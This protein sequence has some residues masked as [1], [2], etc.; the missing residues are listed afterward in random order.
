MA[1][2]GVS[3]TMN[4]RLSLEERLRAVVIGVPAYIRRRRLIED[5]IAAAVRDVRAFRDAGADA[6]AMRA[7]LAELDL[8]RINDL[9]DRH[10]RYYPVEANLPI[11]PVTGGLIDRVTR[12]P[13]QPME[14]VTAATILAQ[15]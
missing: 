12:A 2:G 14:P 8:A 4:F 1:D 3:L 15:L 5:L 7:K 9:I 6:A 10:N 13:F 11:D